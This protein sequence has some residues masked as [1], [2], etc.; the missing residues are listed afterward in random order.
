MGRGGVGR[1]VGELGR[2]VGVICSLR[3][4]I[5]QIRTLTEVRKL[6]RTE[7]SRSLGLLHRSIVAQVRRGVRGVGVC[8]LRVRGH[9]RL[10]RLTH[11]LREIL[12]ETN[13]GREMKYGHGISSVDHQKSIDSTCRLIIERPYG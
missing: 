4:L 3:R 12:R 10:S 5:E 2:T 7:C 1:R 13:E 6:S 8:H 9:S 11:C